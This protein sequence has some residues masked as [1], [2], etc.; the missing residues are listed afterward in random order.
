[1]WLQPSVIPLEQVPRPLMH[2]ANDSVYTA[3]VGADGKLVLFERGNPPFEFKGFGLTAQA[4]IGEVLAL[5]SGPSLSVV[6]RTN[7]EYVKSITKTHKTEP[8][9]KLVM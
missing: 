4:Q 7:P 8:W 5:A 6:A 2:I 9:Y 1:M 3:V